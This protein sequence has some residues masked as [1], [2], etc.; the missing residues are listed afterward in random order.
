MKEVTVIY[1]VEM[2]HVM[3]DLTDEQVNKLVLLSEE[4]QRKLAKAMAKRLD[5][6][7]AHI[8]RYQVHVMDE[9]GGA[10]DG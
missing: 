7:D 10:V 4:E 2:T 9:K 6:D 8:L 3:K 1:N 5:I